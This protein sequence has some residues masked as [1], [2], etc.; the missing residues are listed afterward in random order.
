[1]WL[2]ELPKYQTSSQNC[3]DSEKKSCEI[4]Q[5]Q[6]VRQIGQDEARRRKYSEAF[7]LRR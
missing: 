6:N 1:M 3:A 2:S 7:I 4:M 5:N